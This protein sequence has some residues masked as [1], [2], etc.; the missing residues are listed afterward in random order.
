MKTKKI[1]ILVTTNTFGGIAKLSAMMANDIANRNNKVTIFIPIIPFYTYYINIFDRPLFWILKIVPEYLKKWILN[2]NFVFSKMLNNE[3][4]KKKFIETKFILT[5]ISQED[6]K[7]LD[8]IILNGVGDVFKYKDVDIKKKIYL[9]NQIEE[10]HSGNKKIFE[11]TRGVFDG[12]VITHCNSMKKKL[13]NHVKKIRIVPNPVSSKIW[14]N[15]KKINPNSKRKEILIY[16]K[17]NNFYNLSMKIIREI[18]QLRPKFRI[19]IFA[20]SLYNNKKVKFLADKFKLD[21]LFDQDE[22]QVAKLY[23]SHSFLLYPNTYEDFG[24]PPVEALACGCIPLQRPKIGA[25]D[26]YSINNYN[27]IHLSNNIKKDVIKIITTLENDKKL[28]RLRKN[29]SKK[30]NIFSPKNYGNRIIKG[31]K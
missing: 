22:E 8:C 2:P 31:L 13:S 23:L 3:K 1:G 27:S 16:W 18:R 30:I 4:I 26:M 25:A 24:M 10:V 20:R 12:E 14:V 9:V 17:N 28:K 5:S 11:K 6:L 15:K 21:I 7:L 19:T 29:A